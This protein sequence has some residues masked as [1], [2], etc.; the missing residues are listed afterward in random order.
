MVFTDL[1]N[2]FIVEA[3]FRSGIR[4]QNGIWDYSYQN[5]HQQFQEEF[6][7]VEYTYDCFVQHVR[8]VIDR[9][10]RTGSVVKGKSTGRPTV[11]TEEVVADISQRMDVSPKKS[12]RC[13]SAQT[14]LS[15]ATCRK[16][17][18]KFLHLHPYKIT[19]T[20]ELLPPDFP[21]M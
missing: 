19:V 14:N 17:C 18:K 9:F 2:K 4:N 3:Y 20:H 13:L 12:L 8:R 21:R 7:N 1:H 10:R 11:L 15:V 6:P 16:A 5:C